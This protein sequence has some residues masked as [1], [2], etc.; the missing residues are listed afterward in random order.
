MS[1]GLPA[2]LFDHR[3][4]VWRFREKRGAA[5]REKTRQWRRVQKARRIGLRLKVNHESRADTGGGERTTG[6]YAGVCNA[7]ID[8]LE[9]DVLEVYF[10]PTA[11]IELKVDERDP[12]GGMTAALTLVPF[13]GTLAS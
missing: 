3:A 4:T 6:E 11:P 5:L 7:R 9:G 8:I 12:A 10:G 13:T 2:T 1:Y